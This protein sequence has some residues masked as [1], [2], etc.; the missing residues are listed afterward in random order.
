MIH[1]DDDRDRERAGEFRYYYFTS[2]YDETVAFYRDV[3]GFAVYREW[4]RPDDRG[5]IFRAPAG[6]GLI[7][8][9]AGTTLPASAGGLYIEVAD[10]DDW[11]ERLRG[12]GAP[13]H[14][15]LR[16]TSYGHRSFKTVDP[17]GLEVAFFSY[18]PPGALGGSEAA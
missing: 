6:R 13:I 1:T 16:N 4:S 12:R 15:P 8:I 17:S 2:R 5:T 11:H 14:A 18:L 10:V 3:L 9:E 7:E